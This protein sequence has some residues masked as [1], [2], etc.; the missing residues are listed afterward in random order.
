[1]E[2]ERRR[3]AERPCRRAVAANADDQAVAQRRQDLR[4]RRSSFA[5]HVER[6]ALPAAVSRP[7]VER[8]RRRAPGSARRGRG[9][10]ATLK[11]REHRAT[12]RRARLAPPPQALRRPQRARGT[13]EQHEHRQREQERERRAERHVA[14]HG[15]LALDQVADVDGAR[16]AEQVGRQVGAERRNEDQHA[17]GDDAGRGQRHRHAPERAR[18][19][20]AQ[21]GGGLEQRAVE[22]LERRVER[23]DHERQLAVDLAEQHREVVVEQVAAAAARGGRGSRFTRP[24]ERSM[25]IHAYMRTRKLVQNGRITSTSSALR[26]RAGALQRRASRPPGRPEQAEERGD[27]AR[28]RG[29]ARGSRGRAARAR[30]RS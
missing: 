4:V 18:G 6:E 11:R 13:R 28:G 19:R 1:M 14:R 12:A 15:E 20:G 7:R 30:A 29:C 23:Q 5:Y 25:K 17:A 2:G 10:R 24:S 8:E 3:G 27:E 16:A 26:Q 22:L 9:R 21:V